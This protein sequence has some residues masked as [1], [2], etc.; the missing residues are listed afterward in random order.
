MPTTGT[1]STATEPT[2]TLT[3][4]IQLRRKIQILYAQK[5]VFILGKSDS[6]KSAS[7]HVG[8][9]LGVE[10]ELDEYNSLK[11]ASDCGRTVIFEP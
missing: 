5:I 9:E 3:C 10:V 8:D 1:F 7:D 6:F 2:P 4:L 11:T